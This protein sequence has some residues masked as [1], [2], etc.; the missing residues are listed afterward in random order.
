MQR[1]KGFTSFEATSG[2]LGV[3][4]YTKLPSPLTLT[5]RGQHRRRSQCGCVFARRRLRKPICR[6]PAYHNFFLRVRPVF[7]EAPLLGS[8]CRAVADVRLLPLL[9]H[10]WTC[11]FIPLWI[12]PSSWGALAA[13]AFMIQIGVNGACMFSSVLDSPTFLVYLIACDRGRHRNLSH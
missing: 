12:L 10:R 2:F 6:P 4:L 7:V 1:S 8:L 9:S 3:D 13:G 5:N 11:A